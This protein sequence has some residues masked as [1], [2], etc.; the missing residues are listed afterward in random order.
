MRTCR[1]IPVLIGILLLPLALLAAPPKKVLGPETVV[2]PKE[3][4]LVRVNVTGQAYDYIRPW[5]K[6]APFQKRALGAVLPQGRVLVTADLVANQNYVEL[7]RAESGDKTGANVVVADYEANLALLE[8]TDKKFLNGLTP[9]QLALDTVV[10]DRLAAWQLESTGALVGT[11]G[12]VTTIQMTRYPADLGQFLTYRISISMQYRDNSYTVPLVKNNKLAGLLLRFDS[13]T[14]VLD[15]IPAPIIQHFLKDAET[16]HYRGFPSA[17]F[18]F[19]PTRDPQLR[20]FG[21]QTGK[22]A[23][24]YVTS[25]EPDMPAAKAGLKVGDIVVG[26][27]NNE[28][29]QNGNYVDPLYGK[30]EFTNLITARGF[31]GDTMP[32]QIQREGKAMQLNLA[33]DHREAND[34][35]IP[36]YNIDRAPLYY[37]LGGLVFQELSRQYLREWGANWLKDAPQRFVHKDRFQGELYPEGNRRVVVLTQVLPANSTI[38]Y[39]E[40]AY[41]TVTKVNGKEVK[42]LAELAEIAKQP[43]DGFIKIETEEDPKQLELE[44]A[45][46]E[47]EAAALQQNYGLPSLQR[48]E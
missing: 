35:V 37:V 45:Q 34:Y 24:V 5:Q 41:L 20:S 6:R 8:P 28:I 18:G 26:L 13:R 42:S 44:A 43:M 25:I 38:G 36:P 1:F 15:A 29:D 4:S 10:G 30:I 23:G 46:V 21:G 47:A 32:V 39:D 12:L 7:E 40:M 16:Q 27:G 19:F 17:G 9:L 11:E 3:L 31:A 14:Q 2:K 33:L 22:P 48:L